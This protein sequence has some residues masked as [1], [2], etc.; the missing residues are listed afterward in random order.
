MAVSTG[1]ISAV[2]VFAGTGDLAEGAA[3]AGGVAGDWEAVAGPFDGID[4]VQPE[5]T[6]HTHTRTRSTRQAPLFRIRIKVRMTGSR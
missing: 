5:I 1:V 4:V 6:H 3:V 2:T